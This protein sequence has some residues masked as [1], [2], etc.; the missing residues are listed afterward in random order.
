MLDMSR[1]SP[2]RRTAMNSYTFVAFDAATA[3]LMPCNRLMY[4]KTFPGSSP[5]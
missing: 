4:G 2:V 3:A 5:I 1:L